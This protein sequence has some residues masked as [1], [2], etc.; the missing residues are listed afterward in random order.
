MNSKNIQDFYTYIQSQQTAQKFLLHSYQ[1]IGII[2]PE[3]KSY[4]NCHTFLY[5]LKHGLHF[6]ETG[7]KLTTIIQPILL[8]Y[9]MVHLIKASLL[10]K[11]PNY[12]ES[13]KLLAHGVSSRKRKKKNYTFMDDEVMIHNNGLYSYFS[14]HLYQVNKP[15]LNKFQ[16]K[17]LLTL[18][19][20]M[21]TLLSLDKR[22]VMS[23]VGKF[24]EDS[25]IFNNR[26]L[27]DYHL[28]SR[29]FLERIAPHLPPI[30][31]TNI[32]QQNIQIELT[33]PLT[34][35]FGPFFLH[36]TDQ[37]VYFPTNRKLFLP[38]SETMIHYLLLYNLSMLSRYETE[39]WGDL[40]T[41]RPDIDFPFIKDFLQLTAEKIPLLIGYEMYQDYLTY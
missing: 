1:H 22:P 21:S 5:Y 18:I 24:Q 35:S 11:R 2:N 32:N 13:T 12:P 6:Y 8:F 41:T 20:E 36:M 4:E 7:K 23:S 10:T 39:W 29:A 27:D 40:L 9:G 38:I 33:K 28:T 37:E 31:H 19:P 15:I 26:L 25:L 30:I 16:M 34:K 3:I 17:D 14:N